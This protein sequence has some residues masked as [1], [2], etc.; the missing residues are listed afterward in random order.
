MNKLD[1]AGMGLWGGIAVGLALAGCA[2][3]A[4]RTDPAQDDIRGHA[5]V[6][7]QQAAPL[8]AGPIRLLHADF[9]TRARLKFSRVW[10][11]ETTADCR[12]GT[13]LPWDGRGEVEIGKDE[14]VC[15][16]ATV[17][18]RIWWHARALPAEVTLA[19]QASL[20]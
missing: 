6:A 10:R 18:T 20:P 9:D 17:P 3:S 4:T 7:G 8:V 15:V 5:A 19:H 1:V 13:P 12:N 14:V 2:T 16:V 11:R